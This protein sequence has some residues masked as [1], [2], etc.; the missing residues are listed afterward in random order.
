MGLEVSFFTGREGFRGGQDAD[1]ASLSLC[2]SFS[3]SFIIFLISFIFF[4]LSASISSSVISSL[5]WTR[6]LPGLLGKTVN[7]NQIK[8]KM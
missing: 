6:S 4:F 8:G 3:S 7:T 1:A 2:L 5:C